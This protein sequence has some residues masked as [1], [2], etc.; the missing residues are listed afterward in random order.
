M[1]VE[2]DIILIIDLEVFNEIKKCVKKANPNEACGLIFGSIVEKR[3][4]SREDDY[5]YQY[6]GYKFKCIESTHKSPI[7]FLMDDYTK[8]IEISNTY[9]NEYNYQ[10]ISIFHS[11]PGNA[12]PSG[13]DIPYI[14]GYYKSGISKFKHLI[15]TIMNAIND[16]LNGFIYIFNELRQISVKLKDF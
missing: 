13:I 9:L 2:E 5:S 14:E 1:K 3:K 12:Y 7:A 8:L 6:F 16:K 10:L 11:H 4:N 15:W